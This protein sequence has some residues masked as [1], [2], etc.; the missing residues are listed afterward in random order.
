MRRLFGAAGHH[1]I[2]TNTVPALGA[3]PATTITR[4]YS[5]LEAIADDVD[6]ARVLGGIHWRYD[7]VAGNALGRAVAREVVKN[8]LRAV[9]P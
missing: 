4:K 8:R 6:D 9:H 7:Q 1:I 5:Q 2:L 3:L